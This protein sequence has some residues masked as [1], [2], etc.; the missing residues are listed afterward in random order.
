VTRVEGSGAH[1]KG[2]Q[3]K[4]NRRKTRIIRPRATRN[5]GGEKSQGKLGEGGGGG[6]HEL[7]PDE[8]KKRTLGVNAQVNIWG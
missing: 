2:P 5:P 6:T 7:K 8:N 4:K 1:R 3:K